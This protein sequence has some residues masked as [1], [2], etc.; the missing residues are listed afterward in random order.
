MYLHDSKTQLNYF[1]IFVCLFLCLSGLTAEPA[2]PIIMRV[3]LKYRGGC[4]AT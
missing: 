2:E 1:N 4:R 3:T